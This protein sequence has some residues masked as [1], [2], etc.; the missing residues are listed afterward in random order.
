MIELSATT[1]HLVTLLLREEVFSTTALDHILEQQQRVGGRLADF[2]LDSRLLSEADLLRLYANDGYGLANLETLEQIQSNVARILS[3]NLAYLHKALPFKEN[4]KTLDVAFL[5]P[6]EAATLQTMK[7]LAGREIR[8]FLAPREILNWAIA[9]HYPELL[10]QPADKDTLFDPLENRI[11][12]RLIKS[13]LLTKAQLNEAL[14]ERTPG[15]AGRT[16]E[17][18]LRMGYI[19]EEDLYRT[20]ADQLAMPFAVLPKSFVIPPEV[21]ALFSKADALRH[22]SVPIAAAETQITMLTCEPNLQETVEPLFERKL[23]W[24]LTTPSHLKQ[25]M[26]QLENEF[27]PLCNLLVTLGYL[28]LEQRA[29]AHLKTTAGENLEAVLL[30]IGVTEANLIN[31]KNSL[32]REQVIPLVRP[33]EGMFDLIEPPSE[34]PNPYAH[35][36]SL[37]RR[38]VREELER[39]RKE[40]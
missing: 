32:P 8:I 24:K 11:G 7:G 5:E 3:A 37:L 2:L 25:L 27:D 30:E 14:L 4:G 39:F 36:E 19:S 40:G 10:Q 12:H 29:Q 33:W 35:L 6:P 16:G 31:A 34:A 20:L 17:V 23:V 9:K 22:Q 26:F 1:Q 38:I 13:G 18:L 21:A 28:R 15:K